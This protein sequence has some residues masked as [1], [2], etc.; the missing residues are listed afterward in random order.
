MMV[1][2]DFLITVPRNLNY[3]SQ[4]SEEK[5]SQ[6]FEN[7]LQGYLMLQDLKAEPGNLSVALV[8]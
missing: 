5:E 7:L 8:M 6:E 3:C 1:F 2:S 4:T